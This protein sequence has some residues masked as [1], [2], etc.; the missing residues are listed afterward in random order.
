MCV[1]AGWA[2]LTAALLFVLLS[3]QE[4]LSHL[5]KKRVDLLQVTDAENRLTE[6]GCSFPISCTT[7]AS[8]E[9]GRTLGGSS[10]QEFI[11]TTKAHTSMRISQ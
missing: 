6:L 10:C 3:V 9:V 2:V 5:M 8:S 1:E 11:E 7:K 4:S